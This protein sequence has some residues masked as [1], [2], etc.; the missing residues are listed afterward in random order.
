MKIYNENL[1]ILTLKSFNSTLKKDENQTS[2]PT[3]KMHKLDITRKNRLYSYVTTDS[4]GVR[5]YCTTLLVH[6][7]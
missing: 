5:R 4:T 7:F 3:E 1:E 2:S 6:V